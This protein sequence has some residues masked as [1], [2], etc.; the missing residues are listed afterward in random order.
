M[1]YQMD[2]QAVKL[3]LQSDDGKKAKVL[4]RKDFSDA[5]NDHIWLNGLKQKLVDKAASAKAISAATGEDADAIRERLVWEC[6]EQLLDG[7][8][9][10]KGAGTGKT[11]YLAEAVSDLYG[12][13]LDEAK[14]KVAGLDE[15]KKK[16]LEANP[17]VAAKVA[18]IKARIAAEAA[19]RAAEGLEEDDEEMPEL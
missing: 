12:I 1:K 13:S 14:A 18:G 5:V 11:S 15:G 19:K 17:K 7:N 8:W 9:A 4:C 6:V 3:S 16:A 10:V 2:V